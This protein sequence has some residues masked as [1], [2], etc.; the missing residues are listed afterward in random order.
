M[1]LMLKDASSCLSRGS[2]LIDMLIVADLI[3][4]HTSCV[5]VPRR[6]VSSSSLLPEVINSCISSAY[7][8]QETLFD[9]TRGIGKAIVRSDNGTAEQGR[10]R[11]MSRVRLHCFSFGI[12]LDC[13][14][15]ILKRVSLKMLEGRFWKGSKRKLRTDVIPFYT[16]AIFPLYRTCLHRR[17]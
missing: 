14:P 13:L 17:L 16:T 11:L 3:P 12:R 9:T 5:S 7:T 1:F 15:Y 6:N 2:T 8:V 4:L 10:P